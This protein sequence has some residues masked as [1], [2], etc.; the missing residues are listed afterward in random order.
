MFVLA[1]AAAKTAKKGSGLAEKSAH[2]CR[3]ARVDGEA[4][5]DQHCQ[6]QAG[7]LDCSHRQDAGQ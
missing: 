1:Q 4:A 2:R 7:A 6:R 3:N 5:S